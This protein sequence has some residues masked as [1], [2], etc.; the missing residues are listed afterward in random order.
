MGKRPCSRETGCA[1]KP[2]DRLTIGEAR[3]AQFAKAAR[4]NSLSVIESFAHRAFAE[5]ALQSAAAHAG[6]VRG[7]WDVALAFGEG[8]LDVFPLRSTRA[9]GRPVASDT[10]LSWLSLPFLMRCQVIVR[11]A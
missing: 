1:S 4:G 6:V 11:S 7:F 9:G 2:S 3:C 10:S 8:A 5:L